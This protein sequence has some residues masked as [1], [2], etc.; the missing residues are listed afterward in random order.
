MDVDEDD[1][2]YALDDAVKPEES[3]QDETP[4]SEDKPK[5]E[6]E[7]L[8]EGEEEDEE[9]SDDSDSDIDIITERKDGGQ[10]APPTQARYNE[11]RNVPQ[12]TSTNDTT[13]AVAPIKKE[14]KDKKRAPSVSGADLPGIATSKIDVNA[15]P[16]Y[17]PAGKPITQVNIDEDLNE[18][19]KPWRR[20][21]TD[22]SDYFNYGFDEFTWALYASKQDSLRSEY[23]SEKMALN[24]KK[25]FEE[26]NMMMSMG[27]MPGMAGMAAGGGAP[28]M[29]G[30]PPEMQAMMQQMMATG[31][32]PSQMDPSAMYAAMQGGAGAAGG[33]QGFGQGQN[34][35]MGY[36]YDQ[37]NNSNAGGANRGGGN[38]GGRGRRGR[39]GGCC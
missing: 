24:Q 7:D 10:A 16:V 26:M 12:R 38:F 1:D 29:D 31:M 32:D 34:Q 14:G 22:V 5:D 11:I 28:S 36:A 25:M 15:K 23:S 35:G 6:D 27:G 18:N 17:E 33:A 19:D 8:E 13:P 9:G 37:Q 4:A 21:G 3:K 2:F 20:P 39:G 30:F